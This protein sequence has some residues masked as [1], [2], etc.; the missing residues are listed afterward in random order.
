MKKIIQKTCSITIIGIGFILSPL[1]WWN[2][3][4]INIPLSYLFAV[5]FGALNR[6]LFLPAFITGYWISNILGLI[7]MHHGIKKTLKRKTDSNFK[8]EL[9]KTI[10]FST[11]YTAIIVGLV[12]T[13]IIK[14]PTEYLP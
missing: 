3:L 12:L 13:N 7:L 11:I 1:S 14:F 6:N 4:F 9:I 2:D 8:K 5:P 10:I